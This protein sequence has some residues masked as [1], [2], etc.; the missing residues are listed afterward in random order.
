LVEDVYFSSHKLT[1]IQGE[2][3]RAPSLQQIRCHVR[4]KHIEIEHHF[5][6]E[7]VLDGSIGAME[8][9]SKENVIDIFTKSL[10]KGFELSLDSFKKFTLKGC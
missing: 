7:K 1:I 8:V 2:N 6:C 10:S 9:L 5:I 4:T 3:Q